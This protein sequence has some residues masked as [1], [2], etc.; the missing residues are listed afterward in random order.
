MSLSRWNGK[1]AIVTGV[2]AGIGKA[3][4][5]AFV[6]QGIIVAGIARRCERV[7]KHAKLLRGEKGK[8]YPFKCDLLKESDILAAFQKI[9]ETL[10]PIFILV[11]NAGVGLD[12]ELIDGDTE[13][14]RQGFDTNVM[15]LNI[16]TR[17]AIRNMRANNTK[18]HIIHINS[19]LGHMYVDSEGLSVYPATKFAVTA[20]TEC[21]RRE[22][23]RSKLP[24]K[25]TSI[26]PG[27]VKTEFFVYGY[28]PERASQFTDGRPG[29]EPKDV[30][31]AVLYALSTPEHV[32]VH[33]LIFML[34]GQLY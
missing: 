30:A 27:Y 12:T 15:A 17:E 3:I 10:G 22:I 24:I 34:H 14:W 6:K 31:D 21:L 9:I 13:K 26:S 25:L 20:L 7:E 11:N 16:C 5:E 29:L 8:L 28:S 33:E 19:A 2:S 32:N 4:A 1:V 23:N 18:G